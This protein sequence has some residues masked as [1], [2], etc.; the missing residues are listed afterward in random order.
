MVVAAWVYLSLAR[1]FAKMRMKIVLA[2]R[3]A[4]VSSEKRTRNRQRARE[5]G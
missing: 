5:S 4:K 1:A 2:K 3:D